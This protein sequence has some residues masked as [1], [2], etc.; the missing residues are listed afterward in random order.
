MKWNLLLILLLFISGFGCTSK[1]SFT[2][3]E[4]EEFSSRILSEDLKEIL[5]KLIKLQNLTFD[6]KWT[7]GNYNPNHLFTRILTTEKFVY[8]NL[9][10][11]D[12]GFNG[13]YP[14]QEKMGEHTIDFFID[15]KSLKP[16]RYFD[17]KELNQV[18]GVGPQICEDWYFVKAKFELFQGKLKLTKVSTFF[19]NSYSEE[20]FYDKSDSAFLHKIEVLNVEPEPEHEFQ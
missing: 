10:F 19:D 11:N 15:S 18:S 4:K 20:T 2:I 16:E 8:L 12:C 17:L 5:P 9:T 7:R 6:K 14:F 3:I 13:F 1:D